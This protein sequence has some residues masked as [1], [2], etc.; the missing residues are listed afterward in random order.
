MSCVSEVRARVRAGLLEHKIEKE[1]FRKADEDRDVFSL[2][3]LE[4]Y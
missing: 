2:G 1:I 4:V 3:T